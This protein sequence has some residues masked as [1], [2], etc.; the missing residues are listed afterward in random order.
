MKRKVIV[1]GEI[2]NSY[3]VKK[4]HSHLLPQLRH[5]QDRVEMIEYRIKMLERDDNDNHDNKNNNTTIPNH[6]DGRDAVTSEK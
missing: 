6:R 1:Y 3:V 4:I 5:I 2:E